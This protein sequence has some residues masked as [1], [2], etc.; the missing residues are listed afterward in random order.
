LAP[1][2]IGGVDQQEYATAVGAQNNMRETD[3][4][5]AE[6]E[7]RSTR[8]TDGGGAETEQRNTREHRDLPLKTHH[9]QT[10]HR[11]RP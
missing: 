3:D 4:G 11:M 10:M 6:T 7:Q 1:K 8:E 5:G 9:C 2:Q